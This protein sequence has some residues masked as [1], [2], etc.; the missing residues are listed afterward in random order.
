[1][2]SEGDLSLRP[3]FLLR[4]NEKFVNLNVKGFGDAVDHGWRGYGALLVSADRHGGPIHFPR[5]LILRDHVYFAV[6]SDI[7]R[8]DPRALC[9]EHLSILKAV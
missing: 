6:T 3:G 2:K 9:T 4:R 1:M 8:P 7:F 5:K